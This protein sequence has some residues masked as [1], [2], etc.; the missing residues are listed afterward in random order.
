MTEENVE[1]FSLPLTIHL[2][3]NSQL[4]S[5][6]FL[7]LSLKEIEMSMSELRSIIYESLLQ[8]ISYYQIDNISENNTSITQQT[9]TL[10][11]I[12]IYTPNTSTSPPTDEI[13]YSYSI[14]KDS[15]K[16]YQRYKSNQIS[17][18]IINFQNLN[19]LELY[20]SKIK[21]FEGLIFVLGNDIRDFCL[22]ENWIRDDDSLTILE[23]KNQLERS[24]KLIGDNI[25]QQNSQLSLILAYGYEMPA[26][27]IRVVLQQT[28]TAIDMYGKSYTIYNMIIRQGKLEWMVEHR[29][30]GQSFFPSFFYYSFF[31]FID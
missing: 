6:I 12:Q 10:S 19:L 16:S 3:Y 13:S 14:N 25:Y 29:Y 1:I 26:P 15:L 7:E 28:R 24:Q 5:R 30:S 11:S 20:I 31:V 18:I 17:L 9:T 4:I 22:Y 23:L 27:S 8:T 21:T 2:F